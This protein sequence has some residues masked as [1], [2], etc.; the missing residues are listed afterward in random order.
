MKCIRL[1]L[2]TLLINWERVKNVHM[3]AYYTWMH[4]CIRELLSHTSIIHKLHTLNLDTRARLK[5]HHVCVSVQGILLFWLSGHPHALCT[6]SPSEPN[7]PPPHLYI[8][9]RCQKHAMGASSLPQWIIWSNH[10]LPASLPHT[11]LPSFFQWRATGTTLSPSQP[12]F[13]PT[14][15][16]PSYITPSSHTRNT[17]LP[18]CV[19]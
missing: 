1:V 6:I 13:T 8:Q 4:T 14:L 18:V 2:H 7:L 5:N 16:N 11:T 15:G 12:L 3:Y 10:Q 9:T 17:K 19:V